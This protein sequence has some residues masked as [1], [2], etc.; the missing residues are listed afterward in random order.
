MLRLGSGRRGSHGGMR[1]WGF[2]VLLRVCTLCV[3][4]VPASYHTDLLGQPHM[5]PCP[6]VQ[7]HLIAA[8][9]QAK[10]SAPQGGPPLRLQSRVQ[11][12]SCTLTVYL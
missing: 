7:H 8:A 6:R 5:C 2:G 10:A 11:V 12:A 9:P 4:V 3:E 1:R